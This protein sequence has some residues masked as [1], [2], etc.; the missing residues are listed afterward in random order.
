MKDRLFDWPTV[1]RHLVVGA[2]PFVLAVLLCERLLGEWSIGAMIVILAALLPF[3]AIAWLGYQH[4]KH[5]H[6]RPGHG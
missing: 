2:I 4:W 3:V 5:R 6:D 1:F